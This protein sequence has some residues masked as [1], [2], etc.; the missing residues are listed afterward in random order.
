MKIDLLY[1]WFK[2]YERD[3]KTNVAKWDLLNHIRKETKLN[4]KH[5]K[6]Y[7]DYIQKIVSQ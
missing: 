4:P 7:L 3:I 1:M 5:E 2:I 6:F